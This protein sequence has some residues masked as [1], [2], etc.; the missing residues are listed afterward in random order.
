MARTIRKGVAPR[1]AATREHQEARRLERSA[2]Y[3]PARAAALRRRAD[4]IRTLAARHACA[5]A[6]PSV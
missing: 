6:A 2:A 3:A 1:S 4:A 5:E